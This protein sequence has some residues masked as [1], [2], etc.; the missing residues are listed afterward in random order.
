[1]YPGAKVHVITREARYYAKTRAFTSCHYFASPRGARD[2]VTGR[3]F[4]RSRM[5]IISARQF[6][7][8]HE[9]CVKATLEDPTHLREFVRVSMV[10]A[11]EV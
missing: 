5:K 4:A 2:C 9:R 7:G 10:N 3:D 8:A 1:M 11:F 6:K